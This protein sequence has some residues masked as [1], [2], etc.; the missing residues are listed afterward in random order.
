MS[1]T[2]FQRRLIKCILL[3]H[4]GKDAA[5]TS[6]EIARRIGENDGS[7]S[8]ATRAAIKDIMRTSS[9]PIGAC[10]TGYFVIDSP[11][12]YADYQRDLDE[13]IAGI[14]ERQDILRETYEGISAQTAR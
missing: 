10:S 7:G 4:R 2:K 11:E 3:R 13:R 9:L 8:P 5:I 6:A 12:E 14:K 1:V